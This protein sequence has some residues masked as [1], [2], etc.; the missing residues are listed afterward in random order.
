[1]KHLISNNILTSDTINI[2][3]TLRAPICCI[4]GHVDAGKT[5]LLDSIRSSTIANDEA[6]GITQQIGCTFLPKNYI[7]KKSNTIKGKFST[8]NLTIPGLLM[9]DTPGHEAFFK[10]RQRG[11]SMCDI[12]IIAIDIIEGILP[13][14]KE[15]IQLLK[16]NKIPFVI[17]A[18]KL[19]KVWGW[20]SIE[21][22]ILRKSYK[23]QS[24]EAINSLEGYIESLKVELKNEG[25]KSEFY[26]K[27]KDPQNTHFIIPINSLQNEG[28]SDLLAIVGYLTTNWMTKKLINKGKLKASIMEFFH[29]K[30]LGWIMDVI[31]VNGTLNVGDTVYV[32]KI[33]GVQSVKIKNLLLPSSS[34][35]LDKSKSWKSYDSVNGSCGV[36]VIASD[37]NNVIA[38]GHIYH[39]DDY[40]KG[41]AETKALEEST[42]LFESLPS[43]TE[44]VILMAETIGALEACC[45][46]FNKETIPIKNYQI[47]K[48]TDKIITKL[49]ILIEKEEIINKVI[50]Y[51]GKITKDL[52]KK[53]IDAGLTLINDEVVY[54]L[55]EKYQE[56]KLKTN[57]NITQIL[58]SQGQVALPV[59]MKILKD[60]IFI[61]G[62]TKHFLIGT[63]ILFGK[64]YKGMN[65]SVTTKDN[66]IHLG[67]IESIQKDNEIKDEAVIGDE[68]CL[69]ISNENHLTL[70]RQFN[71]K[72]IIYSTQ[73]RRSI[74][75][76]KKYFRNILTKEDWLMVIEQKKIFGII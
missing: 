74:E 19:D 57:K 38:G 41:G 72:G 52:N 25:I 59:K 36:R 31:I 45:F 37:L 42:N 9:I 13:Q 53:V 43:A 33:G 12:A 18:T 1:M 22:T 28:I 5:S 11:T 44:G 34:V 76:L 16:H 48:I 3:P 35:E 62:G 21:N 65:L 60:F 61:K 49:S 6:G 2:T 17:A 10:L 32:P 73:T 4:M 30:H 29:D 8:E 68:V 66:I 71:E 15:V 69:K 50:L 58:I 63:K 67:I 27:N 14:T 64:I 26:L 47:G 40:E 7:I 54:K 75:N 56:F 20:E 23:K 39:P 24:K 55:I 51:F 46:L 70:G